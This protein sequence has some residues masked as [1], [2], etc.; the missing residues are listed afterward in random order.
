MPSPIREEVMMAH[1]NF[2]QEKR[3]NAIETFKMDKGVLSVTSLSEESDEK[4]YWHA[5]TPHERLKAVELMR[6]INYGYDP[7]TTRIQRVLEVV[8]LK[9]NK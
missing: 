7:A 6:Q 3:M 2:D 8:Q 4:A 5:K 9:Q 1:R